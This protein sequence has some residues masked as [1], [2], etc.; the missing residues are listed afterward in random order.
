MSRRYSIYLYVKQEEKNPNLIQ[1]FS[2]RLAKVVLKMPVV[3]ENLKENLRTEQYS[4]QE[5]E[6]NW[7]YKHAYNLKQLFPF[8]ILGN[9]DPSLFK[10]SLL[11]W[12]EPI[13]HSY[14]FFTIFWNSSLD[15]YIYNIRS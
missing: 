13:Q 9:V 11:S 6:Q 1:A 5:Q 2:Q 3:A 15:F 8:L 7:K 10:K 12:L 4:K 14:F